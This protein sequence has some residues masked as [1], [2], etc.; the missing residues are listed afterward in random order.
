MDLGKEIAK[1]RQ[2]KVC[3]LTPEQDAVRI[4][5]LPIY[6]PVSHI[7]RQIRHYPKNVKI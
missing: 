7:L 5:Y 1:S 4:I 6:T 2:Q 3:N